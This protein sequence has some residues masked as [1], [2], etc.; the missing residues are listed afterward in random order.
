MSVV[1]KQVEANNADA[2]VR[3][4]KIDAQGRAY[5]TGRRKNAI[6]RVWIKPGKGSVT[7]NGRDI[8]IYFGRPVLR[9]ILNQPFAQVA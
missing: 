2:G 4:K 8:E 9:M 6:A 3:V 7:V 1:K 5:S